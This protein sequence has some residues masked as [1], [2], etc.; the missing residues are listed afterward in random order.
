MESK[1]NRIIFI[2]LVGFVIIIG[3]L[4]YITPGHLILYHDTYRRITYF[5]ITI[6]AILFG[7]PGGVILAL[8][9]CVSYIPHLL[10]FWAQGP[11]AYYSELSE[12]IF[13]LA[14]GIVMGFISS[15]KNKLR[16]KLSA[17]YKRLHKQA[18]KLVAAEKQLGESQSLSMLGHVSASFAHEIKNPLGSIKGVAE[19]LGDEVPQGHPKHEFIQIMK[20]EIAR[21]HQSVEDVLEYCRGQQVTKKLKPEP[22]NDTIQKVILLVDSKLKEKQINLQNNFDIT[23]PDFMADSIVMTQVLL[24]I[25]LNAIDAVDKYGKITI[26]H[27]VE[28]RGYKIIIHDN[29]PGVNKEIRQK[30]FEP[31]VTFKEGGTG[32]GLSITKKL[33]ESFNGNISLDGSPKGGASFIIYLPKIDFSTA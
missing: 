12:I 6:G 3:V 18:K 14:A 7:L 15:R 2:T 30:L 22:V 19:I 20:S 16:Q 31:F 24:N 21:L 9:S 1:K 10:M 5:P 8:L 13:Y 27:L 26:D 32:L 17:S 28:N 4:H 23:T 33:L 11:Q 25:I 29:G